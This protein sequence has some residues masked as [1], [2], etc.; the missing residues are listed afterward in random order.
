MLVA[1]AQLGFMRLAAS[2]AVDRASTASAGPRATLLAFGHAYLEHALRRPAEF[3]V[4]FGDSGWSAR[5]PRL[6]LP[7][8]MTTAYEHL[9]QVAGEY[10]AGSPLAIDAPG[11]A[12]MLWAIA[13]GVS[14]LMI[15]GALPLA[16][17]DAR[18]LLERLI[19]GAL[20]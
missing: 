4:M 8:V 7:E 12:N 11:L 16:E 17:A 14:R 19:D 1:I 13:H 3:R 5:D 6:R 18:R 10:L 20:Q 9:E 15:D 2:F